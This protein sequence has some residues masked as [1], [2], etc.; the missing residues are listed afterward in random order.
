MVETR[1]TH[2]N[3]HTESPCAYLNDQSEPGKA[4][5]TPKES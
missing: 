3:T 5:N 4:Q 2:T 1:K